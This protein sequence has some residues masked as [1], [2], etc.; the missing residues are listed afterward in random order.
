MYFF[1]HIPPIQTASK[2]LEARICTELIFEEPDVPSLSEDLPSPSPTENLP[3][4]PGPGPG[5]GPKKNVKKRI[6]LVI[7]TVT[8]KNRKG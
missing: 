7:P 1:F 6:E 4:A 8:I 3:P 5:P 2:T